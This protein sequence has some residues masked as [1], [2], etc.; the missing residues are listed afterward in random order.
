MAL[1]SVE[2]RTVWFLPVTSITMKRKNRK[3]EFF[4]NPDIEEDSWQKTIEEL[5]DELT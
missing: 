1:V 5:Q 4:E 3:P 2:Q